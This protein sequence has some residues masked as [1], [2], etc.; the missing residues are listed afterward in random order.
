MPVWKSAFFILRRYWLLFLPCILFRKLHPFILP[1]SAE[2]V[3]F[4][5]MVIGVIQCSG[6]SKA[7]LLGQG[8]QCPR[9]VMPHRGAIQWEEHPKL[10]MKDTSHSFCSQC[11]KRKMKELVA[12][13]NISVAEASPTVEEVMSHLLLGNFSL[14]YHLLLGTKCS[15]T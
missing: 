6:M 15:N 13:E 3:R 2:I 7:L 5:C 11:L 10:A 4:I 1:P 14:E 12:H 9:H 8:W